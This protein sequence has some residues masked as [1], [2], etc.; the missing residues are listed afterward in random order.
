MWRYLHY[1][2]CQSTDWTPTDRNADHS[3]ENSTKFHND[4]LL[5]YSK[6]FQQKFLIFNNIFILTHQHMLPYEIEIILQSTFPPL[7]FSH[8]NY[9]CFFFW[10]GR[11]LLPSILDSNAIW[12]VL[13]I[14]NWEH[15]FDLWCEALGGNIQIKANCFIKRY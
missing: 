12:N 7:E 8:L 1:R 2:H 11:G 9:I 10:G 6:G 5:Q 15:N 14:V 4:Y 3:C 13:H